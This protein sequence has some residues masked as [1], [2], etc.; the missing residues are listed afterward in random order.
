ME[1]NA[2]MRHVNELDELEHVHPSCMWGFV[3]AINYHQWH[4]NL[5]RMLLQKIT[6]RKRIKGSRNSK[7][8]ELLHDPVE[9]QKLLYEEEKH[10]SSA[11]ESRSK[12]KRS[13]KARIKSL[14]AEEMSKE[15][16]GKQRVSSNAS[17]PK[18]QRT[19]SIHHLE[20]PDQGFGEIC[21]DWEHPVLFFPSNKENSA[22]KLPPKMN[23]QNKRDAHGKSFKELSVKDA[24]KE[25]EHANVLEIFKVNK[26]LFLEI[27]QDKDGSLRK[28]SHTSPGS[29]AKAR[30][31][32]SGS[33]PAADFLQKRSLEPSTLKQKQSETWSA[34]KG[35]KLPT[36]SLLPNLDKFKRSKHARSKSLPLEYINRGSK[37]GQALNFILENTSEPDKVNQEVLTPLKES[38]QLDH[39]EVKKGRDQANSSDLSVLSE[40][41]SGYVSTKLEKDSDN[42]DETTTTCRVDEGNSFNSY[43]A[44]EYSSDKSKRTHRR[45]SSLNESMEK[46]TWLFENNF[47]KEVKLD[48]SRSLK[49][50]NE[51]EM[52]SGGNVSTRF[53]RIRSVSNV[54]VYCSFYGDANLDGWPI[55]TVEV[56][57][58]SHERDSC[59]DELKPVVVSRNTE[60]ISPG[61]VEESVHQN[62]LQERDGRAN[63]VENLGESREKIMGSVEDL[64]EKYDALTVGE[65]TSYS[66]Q[67]NNC[68]AIDPC[69]LPRPSPVP[70]FETCFEEDASSSLEFQ[71]SE[72]CAHFDDKESS[73]NCKNSFDMEP[74]ALFSSM[75][76][77]D[78]VKDA[79]LVGSYNEYDADLD[80][81]K[82]ILENSGFGKDAFHMTLHSSN[83]PIDPLVF[84]EMEAYWHKECSAEDYCGCY[85]H[86]LLFDLVN[87]KLL[88]LYGRSFPYYPKALGSSCYIR[89][90]PVGDRIVD[91]MCNSSVNTLM[92]L[93]TEQKQSL[94]CL[95]ALDMGKDDGWMNLQLESEC[96][97][98][99][100]EDIIFDELLE[101]LLCS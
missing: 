7:A 11:K 22:K 1:K 30:L 100:V 53:R 18:L 19:Y 37:L 38:K 12:H 97:G 39:F 15:G 91:E 76:N 41:S 67:E 84:D 36:G 63:H 98:L 23:V 94:E 88:H 47:G 20:P 68:F 96:V 17:Q 85:H 86:Q 56:E 80:Y 26:D 65:R 49:L 60:E 74:S 2:Y 14:I 57:N 61:G 90:F 40:V 33:F 48:Q 71:A 34:P 92:K 44:E 73:I 54:D 66:E 75:P 13:L 81:V 43:E 62:E 50:K 6:P 58:G 45:S 32:K 78:P 95:V 79:E 46:Y 101:E 59:Q 77:L 5:K 87:E 3:H 24:S 8:K 4:F 28:F 35:E 16:N 29:N 9:Q 93:K 72:G 31:N 51:Y 21:T 10:L 69:E 25:R 82:D 89:P 83:Q 42:R 55:S 70:A 52:E 64:E 27:V 99:E